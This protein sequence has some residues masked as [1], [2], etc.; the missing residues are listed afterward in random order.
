MPQAIHAHYS[1]QNGTD[2]DHVLGAAA[3][4]IDRSELR[5]FVRDC[6]L[7]EQGSPL[8]SRDLDLLFIRCNWDEDGGHRLAGAT[9]SGGTASSSGAT[10][11]GR[12]ERRCGA[13]SQ[14]QLDSNTQLNCAEFAHCLLRM[15]QARLPPRKRGRDLPAQFAEMMESCV[16][17]RAKQDGLASLRD[18]MKTNRPLRQLLFMHRHL[19]SELFRSMC[20]P[21][22]GVLRDRT[23]PT[24]ISLHAFT[25]FVVESGL[26]GK[27]DLALKQVTRIFLQSQSEAYE[28]YSRRTGAVDSEMTCAELTEALVRIAVYAAAPTTTPNRVRGRHHSGDLGVASRIDAATGTGTI[29]VP[30]G[31]GAASNTG[32]GA[33]RQ[34][35]TSATR[36]DASTADDD[37][38]NFALADAVLPILHH[39]FGELE[40]A[41]LKLSWPRLQALLTAEEERLEAIRLDIMRAEFSADGIDS[42]HPPMSTAV[43]AWEL[44]PEAVLRRCLESLEFDTERE[45]GITPSPKQVRRSLRRSLAGVGMAA[46]LGARAR[47]TASTSSRK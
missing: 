38:D 5:L 4:T 6:G 18:A 8:T 29:D 22:R 14:Q 28:T 36:A 42:L 45:L 3:F 2:A 11:L 32:I 1:N 24:H 16:V 12:A 40:G 37:K 7:L 46:R 30:N 25:Q 35:A 17:P 15:S 20:G 31:D 21:A 10:A 34:G 39:L 47:I 44:S 13:G 33:A 9:A 41:S 27:A 23:S 19:L 43:S 26:Q